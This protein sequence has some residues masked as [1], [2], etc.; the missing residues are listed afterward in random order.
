[1]KE[2]P[3][4]YAEGIDTMQRAEANLSFEGRIGA[5]KWNIDKYNWRNK[6]CDR[7]DFIKIKDY[8]DYAIKQIDAKKPL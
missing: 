4:Q 1:M 6:G 3:K 8:C 2:K 5:V 7:E